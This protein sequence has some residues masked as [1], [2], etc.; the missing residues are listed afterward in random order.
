MISEKLEVRS[1]INVN[2]SATG[3]NLDCDVYA[4]I[5]CDF[6]VVDDA[7]YNLAI[8]GESLQQTLKLAIEADMLPAYRKAYPKGV[9]YKEIAT[10]ALPVGSAI[11]DDLEGLIAA[12]GL[13]LVCVAFEKIELASE[14]KMMFE[15]MQAMKNE[16]HL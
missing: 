6:N 14:S 16:W 7:A 12:K 3:L 10:S 15:R 4:T 8:S 11:R 1:L 9:E 5:R 2:D 13:E